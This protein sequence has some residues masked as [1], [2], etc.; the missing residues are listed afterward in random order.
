MSTPLLSVV[1]ATKDREPYCIA[2]IDSIL[3]YN[4][5]R[6]EITIADNSA[7]TQVKEYVEQLKHPAIKYTYDGGPVS[8]ID[9]F[10]RATALATGEFAIM[11]GDDDTILPNCVAIAAWMKQ[12][13]VDAVSSNVYVQY[14]WPTTQASGKGLLIIPTFSRITEKINNRKNLNALFKGG[15]LEYHSYNLPKF[16]H[17]IVRKSKLDAVKQKRGDFFGG[18][19][20]DIYSAVSLAL[21]IEK[22]YIFDF[23]LSIAGVCKTSTSFHEDKRAHCGPLE[24]MPHLQH[25]K[26]P[27]QWN[28]V[29]PRF[30]SGYTVWANSALD[31]IAD[32]GEKELAATFDYYKFYRRLNSIYPEILPDVFPQALE[33][34]REFLGIDVATFAQQLNVVD[35]VSPFAYMANIPKRILRKL[36]STNSTTAGRFEDVPGIQA[37]IEQVAQTLDLASMP[38]L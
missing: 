38:A 7:T 1:I 17:G 28:E 22:G 32:F 19:S 35:K 18:L 4:D 15:I 3:A 8:S 2:A 6:I 21:V 5:D 29:V 12:N 13:N 9:N 34:S 36:K 23:P 26:K 27:Y 14:F 33:H 31:A 20:P 11:I 37:A 30:Y 25:R 10:N 24:E 16:Y